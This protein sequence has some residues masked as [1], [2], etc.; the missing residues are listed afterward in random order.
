[1]LDD[2]NYFA[3][4]DYSDIS[5]TDLSSDNMSTES[6]DTMPIKLSWRNLSYTVTAK[7]RKDDINAIDSNSKFILHNESGYVES[8]EALF[9][10]GA[11]GAG[12]T[13]MLNALC[14]RLVQNR[15]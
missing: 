14:D 6:F 5:S 2:K 7:T 4:N 13:T 3:L 15:K 1:M 10:L 11:S 9:I 12:K 8:G